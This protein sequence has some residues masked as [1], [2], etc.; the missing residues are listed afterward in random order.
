MAKQRKH[1]KK[2]TLRKKKRRMAQHAR[3]HQAKPEVKQY[4]TKER[5]TEDNW[6][7]TV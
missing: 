6:V 4:V 1:A 3:E 2:S 5:E 7:I